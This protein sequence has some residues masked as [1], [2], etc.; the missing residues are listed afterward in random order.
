MDDVVQVLCATID[1]EPRFRELIEG[2]IGEGSVPAF[3][4]FVGETKSERKSRKRKDDEEAK[5]AE[6]TLKKMGKNKFLRH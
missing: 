3:P 6:E 4:A 2:W 1:D 5:E